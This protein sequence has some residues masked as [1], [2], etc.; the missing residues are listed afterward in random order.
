MILSCPRALVVVVAALGSALPARAQTAPPPA[1]PSAA[2]AAPL[3]APPP[4]VPSATSPAAPSA[5]TGSAE[6]TPVEAMRKARS[7]FEY[8]DYASASKLLNHLIDTGRF[9]SGELRG[10]AYRLLGLS[11]FYQ[12]KKGEAYRAFLEM[13]YLNPDAELDPFYVPP[14]AVAFFEQVKEEAEPRLLP[15]RNLKRADEEARRRA[16]IAEARERERLE[17]EEEQRR[18]L[19]VAP[20]VEKRVVQ[21]EFWVNL[22]PF[23]VG[24]LQN[25]DRN[26][27]IVLAT[28]ETIAGATSAGSALLIEELRDS[29]GNF[30]ASVFP[31]AQRLNVAKWIGAGIFYALWIGGAIHAAV[32]YQSETAMPDRLVTPSPLAPPPPEPLPAPTLPPGVELNKAPLPAAVAPLDS[33]APPAPGAKP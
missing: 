22:L 2:P 3:T 21:R 9:E 8:G 25:G 20:T 17:Q 13:L 18:L 29:S 14:S 16:A 28:S 31:L 7:F 24:Q 6:P 11:D 23:G 15:L 33:T 19:R 30:G 5:T 4:V 12:G 26:L 10:E 27:G 1:A 32:N